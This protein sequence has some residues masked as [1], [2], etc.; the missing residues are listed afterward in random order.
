MDAAL[1]LHVLQFVE[2]GEVAIDEDRV[3]ERPRVQKMLSQLQ[4]RRDGGEDEQAHVLGRTERRQPARS[5]TSTG[6]LEGPTPT[7]RAKVANSANSTSKSE[8]KMPV[9][10]C[11]NVRPDAGWTK[12]TKERPES[13]HLA[14]LRALAVAVCP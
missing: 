2:R 12:L 11:Q 6:C 4:F 8:M 3:A 9:A 10:R 13:P 1:G 14:V 7:G 5:S